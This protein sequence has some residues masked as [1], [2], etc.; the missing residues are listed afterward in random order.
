MKEIYDSNLINRKDTASPH[1]VKPRFVYFSAYS[2]S[3]TAAC[4]LFVFPLIKINVRNNRDIVYLNSL[5][6]PSTVQGLLGLP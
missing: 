1:S 6:S 5:V 3:A 2:D 4:F